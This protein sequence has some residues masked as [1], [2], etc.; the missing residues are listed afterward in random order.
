MIVSPYGDELA[1]LVK[2]RG[3]DKV[4][5]LRTELKPRNDYRHRGEILKDIANQHL[6]LIGDEDEETVITSSESRIIKIKMVENL[7]INSNKLGMQI[8]ASQVQQ[9]QEAV[10][11]TSAITL[12]KVLREWIPQAFLGTGLD[13]LLGLLEIP[14]G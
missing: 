8:N 12:K 1:L 13:K 2:I 4:S 10:D 14:V 7:H 6:E 5:P 3:H 11:K 9:I